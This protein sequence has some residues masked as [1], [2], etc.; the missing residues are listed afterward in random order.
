MRVAPGKDR[1][2]K[3]MAGILPRHSLTA[4]SGKGFLAGISDSYVIASC[5]PVRTS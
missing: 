3:S 1:M 5:Y 4:Q 2:G